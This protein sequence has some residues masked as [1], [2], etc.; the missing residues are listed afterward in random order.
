MHSPHT[1][2]SADAVTDNSTRSAVESVTDTLDTVSTEP[3]GQLTPQLTPELTAELDAADAELAAG[4]AEPDEPDDV[5]PQVKAVKMGPKAATAEHPLDL[6]MLPAKRDY[7]RIDAFCR[8][9]VTVPKGTGSG[10][11][12]KLRGWQ[13]DEIVKAMYPPTGARP[14]Q[15]VVSM[16]RGNGKSSL[17]AA[18][19]VYGLLADGIDG[20][21]VLIVASDERQARIV[22]NIARRIIELDQRLYEQVKIFQDKIVCPATDSVM[23]PLPAEPAALQGFDPTLT[24]VDELHVVTEPV[25]DAMALA[26][27]KREQSLTL[28]I[29]TPADKIDSVMWRLVEYGRGHPEDKTFRLVEYGA[30]A[31]CRIDDRDAWHVA[32]RALGDFLH[33]DALEATLKTTREAPFRRYRLGQWVGVADA[34]LPWGVWATRVDPAGRVLPDDG[35]RVCLAFDGSASGDSTALIGCTMDDE[36]PHV[37]TVAVWEAPTDDPRW[38]VPR[39]EVAAMVDAA[40]DRWEVTELA[41]DPWGWRTELEEWTARHAGK[42][43]EW[44]TAH[45]AR[46]APATDRM[47]AAI[48][49]D[50]LTHDGNDTLATHMGNA[51]AKRTPMGDLVSKDK[52]GSTRK[53]D[54]CVAAIVAHDRAAWHRAN[55]P[56]RRRVVVHQ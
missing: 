10:G 17:A 4:A 39:N 11:R 31:D 1:A 33:V 7:R 36:R 12:L 3:A 35:A 41:A 52:R 51:V 27:G 32:N 34:W 2:D 29:S 50:R 6:S 9:F 47:Y 8:E 43:V 28:A 30:P 19:G 25:W 5:K 13:R 55:P 22:F 21:S 26:A 40:F 53:I 20:A 44:N 23:A 14:R 48:A 16:P 15:G 56:K 42:V 37:F 54:A 45:A 38:R 18:L 24:I 46:M 49:T